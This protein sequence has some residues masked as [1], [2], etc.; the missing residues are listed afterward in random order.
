MSSC[1]LDTEEGVL[2]SRFVAKRV[3]SVPGNM[4]ENFFKEKTMTSYYV[5]TE[6]MCFMF[7]T[8]DLP[9]NKQDFYNK[10]RIP[11]LNL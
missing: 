5:E 6:T 1:H 10:S 7:L 4:N 8:S 2:N 11:C 9:G 3:S